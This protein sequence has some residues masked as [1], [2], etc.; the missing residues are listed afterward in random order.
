M[1]KKSLSL[2]GI[3]L[4]I[5]VSLS[6]HNIT[7]ENR[8]KKNPDGYF[9]RINNMHL[10]RGR[11]HHSILLKDGRVLIIGGGGA[12]NSPLIWNAYKSEIYDPKT[13]KFK[14][15]GTLVNKHRNDYTATLLPNGNVLILGGQEGSKE[16]KSAEIFD[17]KSEKFIPINDMN[18]R[19]SDH[20]ATLLKNGKV[21]I[22]GGLVASKKV[23]LYDSKTGKFI[24][25]IDMNQRRAGHSAILLPDGKVF[26]V[27]GYTLGGSYALGGNYISGR[28][29]T[30]AEIYDPKKNTFTIVGNM[31]I[32]RIWAELTLLN[33]NKIL[34]SAN[35]NDNPGVV[36]TELF[37]IN[38]NKFTFAG[39]L[40]EREG[41]TSTL[42]SNGKVLIVGG[43]TGHGP[44][45]RP[46]KTTKIFD[47]ASE[48]FKTGPNLKAAHTGHSA[49]LLMNGNVLVIGG[50]SQVGRPLTG[51]AEIYKY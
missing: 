28:I 50:A 32:G 39:D 16:L 8:N 17:S 26:I 4:V 47:P 13:S 15:I 27:G 45:T 23:E 31:H 21:L 49:I 48:V 6:I 1:N 22:L 40:D 11:D 30:S 41:Y 37:D 7:N 20:T 9:V 33:N 12:I 2:F 43:T 18:Y 51:I 36:Q 24:P 35:T 14:L 10:P 29:L 19:R 42:L 3:I 34:I 46:I 5:I 25:I 44:R 38:T